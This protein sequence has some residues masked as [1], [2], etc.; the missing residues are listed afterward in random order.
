MAEVLVGYGTMQDAVPLV[1]TAGWTEWANYNA[2]TDMGYIL[3]TQIVAYA[4]TFTSSLAI[5]DV[6]GS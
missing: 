5:R 4:Y 1:S 6:M 2:A 3:G